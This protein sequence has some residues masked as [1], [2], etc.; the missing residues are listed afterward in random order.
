MHRSLADEQE[1]L[2]GRTER[3]TSSGG[4]SSF[5]WRLEKG[6]EGRR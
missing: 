1:R 3:G 4:S 2:E 6:A 5:Y